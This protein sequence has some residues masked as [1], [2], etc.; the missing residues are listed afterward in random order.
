MRC[1]TFLFS[2]FPCSADHERDWPPCKVV[3]F[4]LAT[5]ALNVRNNNKTTTTPLAE[6]FP[7]F[8]PSWACHPRSLAHHRGTPSPSYDFEENL[9]IMRH[10]RKAPVVAILGSI[11]IFVCNFGSDVFPLLR[12]LTRHPHSHDDAG[13]YE[14]DF[15]GTV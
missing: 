12:Y 11:H 9:A 4:G 1:Q 3:F 5:N 13:E 15:V 8:P 10:Y 14:Q 6:Q 2:F 7:A